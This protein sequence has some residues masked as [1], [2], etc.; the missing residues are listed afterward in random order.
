MT[1]RG[2]F[3]VFEGIDGS[4]TTTQRRLLAA[5]L[6]ER[7]EQVLETVEPSTSLFGTTIRQHLRREIPPIS[8]AEMAAL[9]SADRHYHV[10]YEV[11]PALER[12]EVVLCDRYV[13]S[14]MAFQ[15][16][17]GVPREEVLDLNRD[18]FCP[19]LTVILTVEVEEAVRRIGARGSEPELFERMDLLRRVQ[20][21]YLGEVGRFPAVQREGSLV[22][23]PRLVVLDTTRSTPEQTAAEVL[24]EF[25]KIYP[26]T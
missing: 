7:G 17:A 21:N 18:F 22:L 15:P 2:L 16:A 5:S 26:N 8:A 25:D 24:A 23:P 14:S 10:E 19:D 9:F 1:P 11:E 13:L 6:R 20:D 3:V 4:G 12:G